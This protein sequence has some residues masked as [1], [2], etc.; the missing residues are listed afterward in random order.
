[1]M[2]KVESNKTAYTT[3]SEELKEIRNGLEVLNGEQ[4]EFALFL[5]NLRK[6]EITTREKIA[7]LKKKTAEASRMIAKS[8]V[9][10]LPADYDDL[11]NEVHRKIEQVNASLTEKPLNM[12]FIQETLFEAA[13]TVDH[14]YNKTRELIENVVLSEK[15]IQYGNRYR[16]RYNTVREGLQAAEEAFRQ[17]D[18]R[19]ALEEA[20]TTIEKV[21]P[22]ALKKIEKMI[23]LEEH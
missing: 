2:N 5:Q 1:V 4:S 19:K 10:G 21:E 23:N 13:D 20:A 18:Y 8:N 12:K 9:P 16:S 17:Y 3:L 11:L 6:D 15:I 7:E 14:F 22:G